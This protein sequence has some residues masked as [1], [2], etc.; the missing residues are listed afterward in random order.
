MEA[1]TRAK[2]HASQRWVFTLAVAFLYAATVLRSVLVFGGDRRVLVLG[3]LL[4]WLLLLLS[5]PAVSGLWRSYFAVCLVLQSVIVA[6]LLP[7]SNGSDFFAILLAVSSMQAIQRWKVRTVVVLIGLFAVLVGVAL[8]GQNGAA[9]A[10]AFAAIYTAANVFLATYA[11][12]SKRATEARERNETL[13]GE[14]RETNRQL[15]DYAARAERLAGARERQRLARD[16]HDS[17]TQTLFSM[18]LTAQSALVLLR[19]QSPDVA[20]QLDQIDRLAHG[21][22]SEVSMLGAELPSSPLADAG[23]LASLRRHLADRELRD[24]LSV[25][26]EVEG[27]DR[28]QAGVEPA[29]LRIVQEALN[30]VVKHAGVS[31]AAVRLRLRPPFRV[32]IEDEGGGFDPGRAD[33]RGLGLTSMRERAAEIG[34]S[35]K[36]SSSPGAGTRVVAEQVSGEEGDRSVEG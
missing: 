23:L 2:P 27:D 19:R 33:A 13:A 31:R 22:L 4:A 26:L 28:P 16:L 18:T 10:V 24:G 20:V 11:L 7:M 34:W 12:A 35:L 30:N 6:V 9:Q 8:A 29:L 36:V 14:L 25:S 21:A 5:E 3:L 17:V 32:E 15:A 1:G